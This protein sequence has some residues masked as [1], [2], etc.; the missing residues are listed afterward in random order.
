MQGGVEKYCEQLYPELTSK[1]GIYVFRRS[2]FLMAGTPVIGSNVGGTPEI[3]DVGETGF[4]FPVSD[5]HALAATI[6]A[7][8]EISNGKYFE[9]SCKV[10]IFAERHFSAEEYYKALINNYTEVINSHTGNMR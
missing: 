2:P 8:M 7:A 6:G 9:M 4:V 3:I 10:R 1:Y 5:A